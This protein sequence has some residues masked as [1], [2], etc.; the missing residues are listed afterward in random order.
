M[1][2][3]KYYSRIVD[4]RLANGYLTS[5]PGLYAAPRVLQVGQKL[6][7][8]KLLNILRRAGY[9]ESEAS[10]VW[11]GRFESRPGQI[12]ISSSRNAYR[13]SSKVTVSFSGDQIAQLQEDQ[14][15]I[16]S[17]T[18]EPEI[19]SNDLSSKSGKRELLNYSEIP[20]PLVHAILSIEDRRFFDHAGID[21]SGLTRAVW[22]NV[23]DER[24]GK[25]VPR[26]RSNSLRTPT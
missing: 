12:E 15:T 24:L 22:R 5:R 26:L 7:Q 10:D 11:S 2:S 3:Y 25:A 19:L 1:H 14:I 17:F 9:V 13:Q 20:L 21:P 4:A 8:E 16:E 6:T 23:G 18:L